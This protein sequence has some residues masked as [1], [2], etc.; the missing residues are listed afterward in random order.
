MIRCREC[1]Q[2]ITAEE[3]VKPS[4]PH[5]VYYHCT[6]KRK[7]TCTQPSIPLREVESQILRF[8]EGITIPDRIH[9]WALAR[10]DRWASE[11][12]T[13]SQVGRR[14]V[15]D[16]LQSVSRQLD[17]L[18]KLRLRDLLTDEEYIQQRKSLEEERIRL[19]Q[20]QE[21][22]AAESWLEPARLVVLFSSRA[23]SWF[24]EGVNQEKRLILA[25]AGSNCTLGDR[26]LSIDAKKPF[27]KWPG[28][29]SFPDMWSTLEDV[30]TRWAEHDPEIMQTV[31]ALRRLPSLTDTDRPIK[32]CTLDL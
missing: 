23:A 22:R 20:Q 5:F 14:S 3:H 9:R 25:V 17:N 18:T 4:G 27:R 2:S 30:R 32:S 29:V 28:T 24:S 13:R 1:G 7:P 10:L 31:A 6:R 8:L 12:A 21:S 19:S 26:Q 15:E 11:E 16:A